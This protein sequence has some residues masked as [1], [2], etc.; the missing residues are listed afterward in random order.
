MKNIWVIS[1]TMLVLGL[2]L[3]CPGSVRA[4]GDALQSGIDHYKA[5]N[6]EEAIGVL[7]EARKQHPGSSIAA[8][9]LGLAYK[10][11]GEYVLSEKNLRDALALDSPIQDAHIELAEVLYIVDKLDEAEEFVITAEKTGVN[12]ARAM[13]LKGLI[14]LKA[15]KSAESIGAFVQAKNMDPSL[16]QAADFQVAMAQVRQQRFSEAKQTLQ[17]LTEFNPSS[18]LA[19]FAREYERALGRTKGPEKRWRMVLGFGYQYDDNVVLK[20][21]TS[22][23]GTEITGESDSSIIATVGAEYRPELQAPWSLLCQYNLYTNTYFDLD[24]H[25]LF[26]QTLSLI[27]GLAVRNGMVSLP[28]TYSHIW[29]HE[30]EYMG[31]FAAIPT[32]QY[33]FHP[34]HIGQFSAGFVSRE[35]IDS[36]VDSDEDRDGSIFSASAGYIHPFYDGNGVAKLMYEFTHDDADGRNWDN[37]GNRIS[38]S[39]LFPLMLNKLNLITAGDMFFQDYLNTHTVFG[40]KREDE[41]YTATVSFRWNVFDDASMNLQYSHVRADSNIAVYDY[42]RNIYTAGIEYRF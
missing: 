42:T 33:A 18:D 3:C 19:S 23:P 6:Y 2:F 17:T 7:A 14:L 38:L 8:F 12:P 29:V 40:K 31:L 21:S 10:Q 41:I 16:T 20:P 36:P 28:V 32:L 5:E 4:S 22:I 15:G 13:F 35:L 39:L 9:Y 37:N 24:S 34:E 30:R 11:T 27:P 25:N 1:F 26:T